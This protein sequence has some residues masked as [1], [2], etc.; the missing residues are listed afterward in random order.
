MSAARQ[1]C[2]DRRFLS[3]SP[4]VKIRTAHQVQVGA[5][6]YV[7]GMP[8]TQ[9][10]RK[11]PI[12]IVGLVDK[13]TAEQQIA[14]LWQQAAQS[15]L[16]PTDGAAAYGVYF[17]YR[18]ELANGYSLL[19]GKESREPLAAAEREILLPAG[20]YAVFQNKGPVPQVVQSLW[21]EIWKNRRSTGQR[22]WNVDYEMYEDGAKHRQVAVHIGLKP[23]C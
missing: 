22:S 16:L 19:V 13:V 11:S 4:G 7:E 12:R 10:Q 18:D 2:N 8:K 5:C 20:N 1:R 23:E 3:E 15:G 14:D 17:D 21:R 9:L 6:A